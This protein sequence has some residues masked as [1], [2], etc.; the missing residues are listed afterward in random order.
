MIEN[1]DIDQMALWT[2]YNAANLLFITHNSL[3]ELDVMQNFSMDEVLQKYCFCDC[4][5]SFDSYFICDDIIYL[6][7]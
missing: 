5:S 1:F 7:I 3:N 4:I 6:D 2:N